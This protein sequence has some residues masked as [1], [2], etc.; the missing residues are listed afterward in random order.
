[1]DNGEKAIEVIKLIAEQ[2]YSMAKACEKLE[3]SRGGFFHRLAKSK[4]LA[5]NYARAVEIRQSLLFEELIEICDAQ[6]QDVTVDGDGNVTIN[7]NVINRNR[8]QID[9]RK[10]VLAKMNPRKYGDKV[11]VTSGGEKIERNLPPWMTA[12]ESES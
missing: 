10:W 2:G 3:L 7:H 5:D 9:T 1:M 11:D 4:E 6:E 12:N 8:L